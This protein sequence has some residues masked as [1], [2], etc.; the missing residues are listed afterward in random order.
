MVRRSRKAI[1][2]PEKLTAGDVVHIIFGVLMVPLGLIILFRTLTAIKTL[3]GFL[4]G[5]AFV[6]FG[7]YRLYIAYVRYNLLRKKTRKKKGLQNFRI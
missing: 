6:S 5:V 1:M 2:P 3:T 7:V 4:V